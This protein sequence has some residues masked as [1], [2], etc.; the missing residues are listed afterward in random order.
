MDKKYP[1]PVAGAFI[2]NPQNQILLVKSFKWAN[3]KLWS[4]PGGR[5]EMRELIKDAV[6]REAYEEVGLNV[7]FIKVF[8]VF[9]A[10][11]PKSFYK[12]HHFIFLECLCKTRELNFLIDKREI[13][14][15]R[16]FNFKDLENI[17]LETFTKKAIEV[18]DKEINL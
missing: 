4:V 6:R 9:D 10:I 5:V 12:P 17:Q 14:E 15:A 2:V 8:A 11:N 1:Q 13:Q 16:W 3:G 18:L 7:K